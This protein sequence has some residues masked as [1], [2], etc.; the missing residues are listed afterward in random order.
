[1]A[2]GKL[3]KRAKYKTSVKVPGVPGVLKLTKERF[4]FMPNDPTL[5]TKLN[6]EFKLIK[7]HKSSKECSSKQALLNLT[8]AQVR[9]Y[10]W[11]S[12][13]LVSPYYE[14]DRFL[15]MSGQV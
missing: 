9:V 10:V 3:V 14:S 15:S 6:V 11:K 13:L 7:G 4:Y 1:M 8:Q 2:D 12:I 5:T